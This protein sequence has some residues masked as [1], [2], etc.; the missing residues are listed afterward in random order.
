MY[1]FVHFLNLPRV[2]K[3]FLNGL[4]DFL[5]TRALVDTL[6]NSVPHQLGGY[7]TL[8]LCMGSQHQLIMWA[9]DY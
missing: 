7:V 9:S 2:I 3:Y 4:P 5:I 6:S 8:Q 1:I